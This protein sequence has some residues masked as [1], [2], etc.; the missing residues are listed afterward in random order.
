MLVAHLCSP[1]IGLSVMLFCQTIDLVITVDTFYWFL[2][3]KSP[4]NQSEA[5][6]NENRSALSGC[7]IHVFNS[8]SF[9]AFLL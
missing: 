2:L 7:A 6:L 1:P 3:S 8:V 4:L 9:C 5:L